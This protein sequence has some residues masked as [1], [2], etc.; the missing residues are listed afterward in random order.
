MDIC[1][2]ASI[3]GMFGMGCFVCAQVESVADKTS[4]S[5]IGADLRSNGIPS[6]ED[7]VVGRQRKTLRDARRSRGNQIRRVI[8]GGIGGEVAN[9]M[10]RRR[11]EGAISSAGR[12]RG[13]RVD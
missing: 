7:C 11:C 6:L 5:K 12:E 8:R 9:W 3:P 10:T 1:A 13:M 4:G 2:L